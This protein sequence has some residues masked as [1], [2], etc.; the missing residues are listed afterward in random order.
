MLAVAA[1]R[2]RWVPPISAA[3]WAPGGKQHIAGMQLPGLSPGET[4]PSASTVTLPAVPLPTSECT[5]IAEDNAA[6][7][8]V[9]AAGDDGGLAGVGAAE[10]RVPAPVLVKPPSPAVPSVQLMVSPRRS[11]A[12]TG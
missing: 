1:G 4:A 11:R 6:I 9:P 10:E 12:P 2:R 8:L 7:D 5:S 3:K